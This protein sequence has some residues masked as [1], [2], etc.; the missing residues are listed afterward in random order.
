MYWDEIRPSQIPGLHFL[1]RRVIRRLR[2][3]SMVKRAVKF[4]PGP[5]CKNIPIGEGAPAVS[6]AA[7]GASQNGWIVVD[8]KRGWP[9]AVK[10][11]NTAHFAIRALQYALT[12][13]TAAR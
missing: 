6:P 13:S 7:S 12:K 4:L 5:D 9:P 1:P 11:P 8:A 10:M 2:R 3:P